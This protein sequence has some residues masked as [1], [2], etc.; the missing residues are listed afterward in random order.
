MRRRRKINEEATTVNPYGAYLRKNYQISPVRGVVLDYHGHDYEA[1]L[2]RRELENDFVNPASYMIGNLDNT[3]N[4]IINLFK[5]ISDL[6]ETIV[7]YIDFPMLSKKQKAAIKN[8]K[9]KLDEINTILTK[10]VLSSL[11][12]LG[13]ADQIKPREI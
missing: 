1:W 9:N 2:R 13:T 10:D 7:G 3:E 6:K 4:Q 12:E 5:E 11:D 8:I